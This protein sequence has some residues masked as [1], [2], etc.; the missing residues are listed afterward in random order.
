[1]G[2]SVETRARD[3]V[4]GP[5]TKV[6]DTDRVSF[7]YSKVPLALGAEPLRLTPEGSAA[8]AVM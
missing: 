4:I 1:M 3:S 5:A 2:A 7:R 8:D 6:I